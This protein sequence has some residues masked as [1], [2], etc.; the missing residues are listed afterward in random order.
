MVYRAVAGSLD[1][2]LGFK[3]SRTNSL[4]G[5]CVTTG[6]ILYSKDTQTDERV[7]KVAAKK[8][9]AKSMLVVPLKFQEMNV[10]VLKVISSKKDY[11]NEQTQCILG[12]MSKTMGASMYF[13]TNHSIENLLERATKDS[14]TGVDNRASFFEK[15]RLTFTKPLGISVLFIDMNGLKKINDT[16]GHQAGDEAIKELS[17]RLKQAS[18]IN[19]TIARLGGDEFG[20]ILSSTTADNIETIIERYKETINK[21]FQYKEH[22]LSFSASI[23]YATCP[24]DSENPIEL[25]EIADK[26]MYQNK[27]SSI[28]N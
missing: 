19:D 22:T 26:R 15:L 2:F 27:N 4:S 25:I 16:Y 6:E 8:V 12:I 9:G 14:M 23:G 10:G 20:V 24:N 17:N 7:D 11:F 3:V 13:S 5:M 1:S 21:P 18:R 28:K